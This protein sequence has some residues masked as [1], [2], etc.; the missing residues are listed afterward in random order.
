MA[1]S[2]LAR[3]TAR[4]LPQQPPCRAS[5]QRAPADKY[6]SFALAR[7]GLLPA[8]RTSLLHNHHTSR[9]DV[10]PPGRR[11][12]P[13]DGCLRFQQPELLQAAPHLTPRHVFLESS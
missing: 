6:F 3:S 12:P 9:E 7:L 5:L 11:F 1:S 2:S 10:A 4:L 8:G 13:L